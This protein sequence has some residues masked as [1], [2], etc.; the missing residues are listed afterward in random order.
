MSYAYQKDNFSKAAKKYGI[1]LDRWLSFTT[2]QR[3]QIS[4]RYKAGLRGEEL[5]E[6]N[7]HA[8]RIERNALKAANKY[9]IPID[10][11]KS[12]TKNQKILINCRYRQGLR[13]F[14]DLTKGLITT[15]E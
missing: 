12:L 3:R 8:S 15:Q 14:D 5:F 9:Q 7:G 4:V 13:G 10:Q 2:N 6:F 11:Y 1:T